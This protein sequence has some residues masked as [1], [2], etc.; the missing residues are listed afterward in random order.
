MTKNFHFF[1]MLF[2]FFA[3]SLGHLLDNKFLFYWGAFWTTYEIYRYLTTPDEK[4]E[5]DD[6]IR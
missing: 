2:Q 4:K 1:A 5:D 3:M 6:A